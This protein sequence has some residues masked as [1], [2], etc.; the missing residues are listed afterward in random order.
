MAEIRPETLLE[1]ASGPAET[2]VAEARNL[3]RIRMD[4]RFTVQSVELLGE[5][6]DE[7]L[8]SDLEGAIGDAFREAMQQVLEQSIHKLRAIGES[9]NADGQQ[10]SRTSPI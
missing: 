4:H 3:V 10:A 5:A 6:V 1:F 9:Q 8:R 2:V 7:K